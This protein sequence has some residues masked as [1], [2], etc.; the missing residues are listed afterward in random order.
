[1]PAFSLIYMNVNNNDWDKFE[2]LRLGYSDA[3]MDHV[4][5]VGYVPAR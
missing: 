3:G 1:M 4:A 5:D 2:L